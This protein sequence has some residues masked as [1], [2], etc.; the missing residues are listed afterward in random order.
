MTRTRLCKK[1]TYNMRYKLFTKTVYNPTH[2]SCKTHN[3]LF[4]H[5]NDI[6]PTYI[7]S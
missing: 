3:N 6:I 7:Y 1:M 5:E 2:G 4:T